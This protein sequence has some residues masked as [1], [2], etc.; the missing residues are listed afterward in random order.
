MTHGKLHKRRIREILDTDYYIKKL[1]TSSTSTWAI[2]QSFYSRRSDLV[3][4]GGL[5]DVG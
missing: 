1:S 4:A 5:V 3:V 2:V